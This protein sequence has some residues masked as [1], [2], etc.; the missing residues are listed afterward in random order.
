MLLP[1][2]A[3]AGGWLAGLISAWLSDLLQVQDGLP[4]AARGPLVRDLLVQLPL[5][6]IWAAL[7]VRGLDQ[8]WRWLAA[9]VLTVPIV[10][11]AV[12]DL[13]HRYVYTVV[14]GVGLVLGL[15]L[16]WLVNQAAW[17]WGPL[18]ALIGFA[19]FGLFFL[20]GRFLYRG[21]LDEEPLASGD[22]TIATMVGAIA[23]PQAL[24]ALIIG[25]FASA[26][27]SLAVAVAKRSLRVYL[28]YGPG[29]CVGGLITLLF[30][31]SK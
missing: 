27:F 11:V 19:M 26:L 21:R 16:G 22:I 8:D 7:A 23:G 2:A 18:G 3:A 4:S 28:P 13:R 6:G 17:W 1:V 30:A 24:T 29:L 15:G 10:Q 25:I 20:L 31:S 14:A 9:A 12:T 5:A